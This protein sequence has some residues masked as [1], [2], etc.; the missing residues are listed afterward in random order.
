MR[1]NPHQQTRKKGTPPT[2]SK[3]ILTRTQ[4]ATTAQ[5]FCEST[6]NARGIHRGV[7]PRYT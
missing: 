5:G 4:P 1:I 2:E 7:S 3:T 6:L